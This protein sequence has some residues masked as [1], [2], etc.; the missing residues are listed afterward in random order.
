MINPLIFVAYHKKFPIIYP[1]AVTPIHVGRA[2]HTTV[3]KDGIMSDADF[4]ELMINMIGDDTGDNISKK[5]RQFNEMTGIYWIWKNIHKFPDTTHIGFMQYRRHF[6]LNDD[7]YNIAPNDKEKQ[8]YGCVHVSSSKLNYNYFS[9]SKLISLLEKYDCI[10]PIAGD[11]SIFG[12]ESLWH[13][14]ADRIEGIHIDDLILLTEIVKKIDSEFGADLEIYLNQN[15]KYMY[16]MFI[17][18][19]NEFLKYC[20]FIFR[21][22]FELEQELDTSLYTV[23]GKRTMG[24]LAELL[25]GCYITRIKKDGTV[26]IKECGIAYLENK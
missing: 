18:K 4:N 8:A 15:K 2:L 12:I 5:N 20:E 11:F 7:I 17:L 22:L 25:Y 3:S 23:N 24:Y 1:E 13:D 9:I 19:K 26:K 21:C 6:I 10:F 14:Y 16:Q